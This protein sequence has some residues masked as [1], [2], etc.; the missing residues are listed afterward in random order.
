MKLLMIS[1]DRSILAGKKGP[2][3]ATL[4]GLSK[5]FE[6]IDVITPRVTK[7]AKVEVPANVF[8]HPST[9]GL[10]YQYTWAFRTG[11]A[12]ISAH[13]HDVM[14]VHE[15]PPFYN[16][17]AA[18]LLSRATGIPY[19][20]EI[21]HIVGW[22]TAASGSEV[23]GRILSRLFLPIE[24]WG[25]TSIRV[26]NSTMRQLLT[27]WWIPQK[28]IAVVPSFYLDR[29]ALSAVTQREKK[30]DVVFAGRMVANKGLLELLRAM[31]LLPGSTLLLLG[32][33]SERG[34]SEAEAK[35]LGITDRVTFAGWQNSQETLWS[36]M[37]Q[38]KV[39]VMSSKSEG[40]PRVAL[41]A[42]ALGLPLVATRVG[43]LP[44]VIRDGENGVFTTGS[45]QDIAAKLRTLLRDD[46]ERTHIS[47]A[48]PKILDTFDG[49]K[50]LKGYADFLKGLAH[51]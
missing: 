35:K 31:A 4:E 47:E 51:L 34:R 48:A 32:D 3:A 23:L 40:G 46:A 49:Q 9:R 19:A 42:M 2:F 33:G 20:L 15:Y 38:A 24:S 14:T 1:G 26:V 18:W 44:D 30:F 7:A 13:R 5:E 29:A 16:G 6:R 22:P 10:W 21:H 11:R 50:L 25:A 37:T 39:A 36:A 27:R 45:P 43:V 12:L 8:F 28:K 17:C 41:E